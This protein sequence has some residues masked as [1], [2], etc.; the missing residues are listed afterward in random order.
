MNNDEKGKQNNE[1][2]MKTDKT[3]FRFTR[4]ILS[5]YV[6]DNIKLKQDCGTEDDEEEEFSILM[7][8]WCQLKMTKWRQISKRVER[9]CTREYASPIIPNQ[10]NLK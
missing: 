1:D 7:E 2:R 4:D 5:S 6:K 9:E 3:G 10:W 8:D